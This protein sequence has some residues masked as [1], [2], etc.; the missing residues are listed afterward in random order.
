M[1]QFDVLDSALSYPKVLLPMLVRKTVWHPELR[2]KRIKMVGQMHR[3]TLL[4][5]VEDGCRART[6]SRVFAGADK[7]IVANALA[8]HKKLRRPPCFTSSWLH[9]SR[10]E[11]SH[12]YVSVLSL[13]QITW[14]KTQ[15][16][17]HRSYEII[18]SWLYPRP[19]QRTAQLLTLLRYAGV[20]F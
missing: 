15:L 16:K 18:Y 6:R 10:N 2:I 9:H 20:A 5:I 4:Y 13:G 14:T 3:P 8:T 17:V 12:K 11:L 7:L 19:H 1:I